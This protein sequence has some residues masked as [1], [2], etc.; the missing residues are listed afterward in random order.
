VT[1]AHDGSAYDEDLM[2]AVTELGDA[3]R[4]LVD[5]SVRTT[6]GAA[7]LRAAAGL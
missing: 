6:V 2:A 1:S 4:A 5:T 3:L 7:E